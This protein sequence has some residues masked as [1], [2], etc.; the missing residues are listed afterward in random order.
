MSSVHVQICANIRLLCSFPSSKATESPRQFQLCRQR[1]RGRRAPKS[2]RGQYVGV[3]GWNEFNSQFRVWEI[4]YY[5][6]IYICTNTT[7]IRI[8][9][10]ETNQ[11]PTSGMFKRL[12]EILGLAQLNDWWLE[13]NQSSQQPRWSQCSMVPGGLHDIFIFGNV[14]QILMEM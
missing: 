12:T 7:I 10:W 2:Y 8:N 11:S 5:I 14:R 13:D 3:K 4:K 6:Y 1:P 9:S